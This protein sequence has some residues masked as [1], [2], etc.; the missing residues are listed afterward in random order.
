MICA[1]CLFP[2][3]RIKVI[4]G[5]EFCPNCYPISESGGHK[6]DGILTRNSFRAR[7]QQ[8]QHKGD[9]LQPHAYDKNA[10]SLK[11]SE[12]FI[13]MYPNQAHQY[14]TDAEVKQSHPKLAKLM[15][16]NRKAKEQASQGVK[17]SGNAKR[18]MEKLLK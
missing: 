13:K 4:E 12:D 1:N 5:Q 10:H 3:G 2:A 6:I 7:S 11:P 18:G 14:F 17:F 8:E 9:F 15:R 16:R